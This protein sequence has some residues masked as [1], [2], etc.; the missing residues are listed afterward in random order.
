MELVENKKRSELGGGRVKGSEVAGWKRGKSKL[1]V[2]FPQGMASL[3]C[4][5]TV[6]PSTPC[7]RSGSEC[8]LASLC[9]S[10]CSNTCSYRPI[11]ASTNVST[12]INKVV[13]DVLVISAFTLEQV[14]VCLLS[15]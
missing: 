1:M 6:T 11:C 13:V 15:F 10:V 8:L 5:I 2:C 3:F 9:A 14:E 7:G 4:E 12:N